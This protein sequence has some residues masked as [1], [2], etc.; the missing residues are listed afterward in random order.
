MKVVLIALLL[1]QSP[2]ETNPVKIV[3]GTF[4]KLYQ[5]LIS[6][7]Q[8]DVCNFSPSCSHFA[9]KSIDT[10]GI[11]WGSLMASDRLLRCNPWV[12]QSF[13]KYYVGIKDRKYYDP[14][15]NNFIL[16]PIQRHQRKDTVSKARN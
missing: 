16:K 5:T 12:H 9:S 1:T 15:E 10:H 4:L 6:P 3:T 11:F 8:G 7:S 2:H 13:N 14:I